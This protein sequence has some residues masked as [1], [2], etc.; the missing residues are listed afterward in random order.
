MF[1]VSQK[2]RKKNINDVSDYIGNKCRIASGNGNAVNEENIENDTSFKVLNEQQNYKKFDVLQNHC[3]LSILAEMPAI[4]EN[5]RQSILAENSS[6]IQGNVKKKGNLSNVNESFR[7]K[8][9]KFPH[10]SIKAN[11]KRT[12]SYTPNSG[13]NFHYSA[14]QQHF[15][16]HCR[17]STMLQI[18]SSDSSSHKSDLTDCSDSSDLKFRKNF[19]E[20]HFLSK[21][22]EKSDFDRN[23]QNS[24]TLNNFKSFSKK[25]PEKTAIQESSENNKSLNSPICSNDLVNEGLGAVLDVI[26]KKQG[27]CS[28]KSSK[29]KEK[30]NVNNPEFENKN[31]QQ[32]MRSEEAEI[33][34][35]VFGRNKKTSMKSKEIRN[36][37]ESESNNARQYQKNEGILEKQQ[38]N[39]KQNFKNCM[40]GEERQKDYSMAGSE[41]H[42]TK[43]A[44]NKSDKI[45]NDK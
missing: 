31:K 38:K 40:H 34:T 39:I 1:E 30:V 27:E 25:K 24:A 22:S 23:V 17:D 43:S 32:T 29:G 5:V 37:I 41:L 36:Q 12:A 8:S 3:D 19:K 6:E 45:K 7:G 11:K 13:H 2:K 33:K 26:N 28:V 21:K 10:K 14:N 35:S 9:L 15:K 4:Q 44:A 18:R 20:S 16:S 42:F